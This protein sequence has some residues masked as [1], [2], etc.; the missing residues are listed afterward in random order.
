MSDLLIK[1][2]NEMPSVA[3]KQYEQELR[4][5]QEMHDREARSLEVTNEGIDGVR[6]VLD[7]MKSNAEHIDISRYEYQ[8]RALVPQELLAAGLNRP[9]YSQEDM[10]LEFM[11]SYTQYPMSLL[12]E[13]LKPAI[14][15][16][17]ARAAG[18]RTTV[19]EA[20]QLVEL[21]RK[22]SPDFEA[23]ETEYRGWVDEFNAEYGG[24]AEAICP[25]EMP[26]I[27]L[28]Y[29]TTA[30]QARDD[31]FSFMEARKKMFGLGQ[32]KKVPLGPK[33][34]PGISFR[35]PG[36]SVC[37]FEFYNRADWPIVD[38]N[39]VVVPGRGL[40]YPA[41]MDAFLTH[42]KQALLKD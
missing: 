26:F 5:L 17:E 1:I 6:P 21:Q 24:I 3:R 34:A 13:H 30:E 8:I 12:L 36:V 14:E 23:I 37:D 39:C 4:E 35:G 22:E 27:L 42:K 32:Y 7:L 2:V 10:G 18:L 11:T 25:G 20:R 28:T 33:S 41:V 9:V 40:P 19:E 16:R 15:R 31:L 29:D 38:S